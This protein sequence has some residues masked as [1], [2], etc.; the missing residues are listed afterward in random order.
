MKLDPP[1][2]KNETNKKRT[3]EQWNLFMAASPAVPH[4]GMWKGPTVNIS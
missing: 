2:K 3:D 4:P 1:G